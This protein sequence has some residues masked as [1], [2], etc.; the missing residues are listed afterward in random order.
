MGVMKSR[1]PPDTV[2]CSSLLHGYCENDKAGEVTKI[3]HEMIK[4]CCFPNTYTCDILLHSLWDKGGKLSSAIRVLKDMD[5]KGCGK[6]L[7][8]YNSL[9][10][11]LG[12]KGQI[13]EMYGLMDEMKERGVSPNV[14][15]YNNL[16]SCLCDND[17]AEDINLLDEKV[18]EFVPA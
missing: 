9:I 15:T 7:V 12:R 2:T 14:D 4:S 18:G 10:R 3:L 6:N 16:I 5:E 17:R 11:G 13:Y 1:V 8:T